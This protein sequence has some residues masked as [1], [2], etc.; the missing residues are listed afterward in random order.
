MQVYKKIYKL[1]KACTSL[2]DGVDTV[3]YRLIS[4]SL[5]LLELQRRTADDKDIVTL[6][7]EVTCKV[8]QNLSS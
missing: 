6:I 2:T 3:I 5:A 4:E 1:E 7:S 8:P